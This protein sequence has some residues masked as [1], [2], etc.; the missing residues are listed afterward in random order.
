MTS[1]EIAL[2][3]A[4]AADFPRLSTPTGSVERVTTFKLLG[5]NFEA[6]LSWSLHSSTISAKPVCILSKTAEL[7]KRAGFLL[8]WMEFSEFCV[9]ITLVF[10]SFLNHV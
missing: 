6:N 2:I 9:E 1:L 10:M 4:K 3:T 8:V 7:L 5:T